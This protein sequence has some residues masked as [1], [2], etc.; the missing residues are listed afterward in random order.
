LPVMPGTE[1]LRAA[2]RARFA[3]GMAARMT[4]AAGGAFAAQQQAYMR[5]I[6]VLD[7]DKADALAQLSSRSDPASVGR[8][9]AD[10]LTLDLRPKLDQIS[11]P[12]LVLMPYFDLDAG[13]QGQ[14]VDTKL[15]YY[16]ALMEGTP[17]LQVLPVAPA[18]H[19]AMLDQPQAVIAALSAFLDGL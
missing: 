8:Y 7:M 5:T 13:Q 3:Q 1:A 9:A 4:Q 16:K 10:L 6:G 17:K 2:E 19:F 14:T 12:V 18:R 15:G 11:A